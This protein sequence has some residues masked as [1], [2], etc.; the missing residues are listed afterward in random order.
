[1]RSKNIGC[2]QT[3]VGLALSLI[4]PWF[5]RLGLTFCGYVCSLF[6]LVASK[7][8][9]WITNERI[10]ARSV[11]FITKSRVGWNADIG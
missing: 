3:C 4:I 10:V 7:L 6:A 11:S 1:M 8:R 5:T 2:V 9:V